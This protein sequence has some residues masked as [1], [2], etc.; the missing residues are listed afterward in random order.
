MSRIPSELRYTPT[1]EWVRIDPS[2]VATVGITEF[3]QDSLGDIVFVE[4][5]KI[6]RRVVAGEVVGVIESVKA[7]SDFYAPIAGEVVEI[8]EGLVDHWEK[9]NQDAYGAWLYKLKPNA[10]NDAERLLDAS[11][12]A[13]KTA[14][15]N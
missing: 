7:A 5:P 6:G 13:S 15:T 9:I 11:A 8:N 14:A 4:T 3:A 1:H 10:S 2:G 12:Y